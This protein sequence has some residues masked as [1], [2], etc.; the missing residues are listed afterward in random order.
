MQ[1]ALPAE[2]RPILSALQAV[3]VLRQWSGRSS[4]KNTA[5]NQW[6]VSICRRP[7][8]TE[9]LPDIEG[10]IVILVI[11][12]RYQ[13]ITSTSIFVSTSSSARRIDDFIFFCRAS[14]QS[15][16]IMRLLLISNSTTRLVGA[17]DRA[18]VQYKNAY[19]WSGQTRFTHSSWAWIS[20]SNLVLV[21]DGHCI[22]SSVF[23]G[24]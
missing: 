8:G 15:L 9:C 6:F 24:F 22:R 20:L 18:L 1:S 11:V 13:S 21:E 19:Q 5:R 17:D 3:A 4:G 14:R 2:L 7:A 16:A 23:K 10:D 12:N